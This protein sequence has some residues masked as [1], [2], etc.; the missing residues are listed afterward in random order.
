MYGAGKER[1]GRKTQSGFGSGGTVF[2]RSIW[3]ERDGF[4]RT[5]H[6]A[7]TAVFVFLPFPE[8]IFFFFFSENEAIFSRNLLCLL[9]IRGDYRLINI[10]CVEAAVG[11][12]G[13]RAWRILRLSFSA[14][15]AV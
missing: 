11:W 12:G 9:P 13:G 4:V 15:V 14:R 10:V 1:K 3:P 6:K 8:T 7:R 2:F 5:A